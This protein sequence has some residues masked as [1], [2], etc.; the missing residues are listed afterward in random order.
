MCSNS[1]KESTFCQREL[2]YGL[3]SHYGKYRGRYRRVIPVVI[4]GEC[5]SQLNTYR[6]RP[7]RAAAFSEVY[8]KDMVNSLL[9]AMKLGMCTIIKCVFM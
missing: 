7:I 1:F 9:K 4:E 3:E 6:I 2:K 5:P 8:D